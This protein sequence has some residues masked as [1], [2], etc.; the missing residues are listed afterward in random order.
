[1][2]GRGPS[3]RVFADADA[4][5]PAVVG[6]TEATELNADD[7]VF[8]VVVLLAE[9]LPMPMPMLMRLQSLV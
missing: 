6:L 3:S 4:H 1:M 5:A 8:V 9:C 7:R 2:R